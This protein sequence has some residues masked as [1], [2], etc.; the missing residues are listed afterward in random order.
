MPVLPFSDVLEQI[1]A[2]LPPAVEAYLVGGAVR[3]RLLNRHVYDLDF[4][5]SEEPLA[6]SRK[7]ADKSGGAYYPLDDKRE[8]GRVIIPR[9]DG[10]R[11]I[12]DFALIQGD[13]LYSDLQA[14]DFSINAMAL[15]LRNPYQLID[16][17]GGAA[18]LHAGVLRQCTTSS[19]ADDP[20]RSLRAV[21]LASTFRLQML[22]ETVQ[23][24][25]QVGHLLTRVSAERIRDELFR[26]LDSP[27]P[28]ANIRVLDMLD[29]LPLVLPELG[30]LKNVPQSSP[31]QDDVW[32]H[33]LDVLA[34]LDTIIHVLGG[35]HD[36]DLAANWTHG[37]LSV[38]LG[39]FRENIRDH[40][41]LS[42]S[43][44]RTNKQLLYLAALYHDIGKPQTLKED[45]DG[46][47]RFFNHDTE[48]A[49]IV[50]VRARRLRLSNEEIH[51]I[52]TIVRHH[53]RPLM[54]AHVGHIP[55]K[56]AIYRFYRAT[57][58]AGIDVCLHSLADT[59]ATFGTRLSEDIWQRDVNIVRTLLEAWWEQ[60]EV[61]VSPPALLGGRD[62][63]DNLGLVPGP[64]VGDLLEV[65]REAQAS[66]QVHDREEALAF[67]QNWLK[68]KKQVR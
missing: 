40:L 22:P 15:D 67:A 30:E 31:H 6:V 49:R 60:Q 34:K 27:N 45:D 50:S 14:R 25:R 37:Y 52:K 4:V 66:G 3:D 53:M 39:N 26:I 55:T 18:D 5:L 41:S 9:D 68:E 62:L 38:Q 32:H 28:A 42:I 20:I 63:I 13:D 23:A 17:L 58:A 35:D 29:L 64:L 36:P 21:R 11:L 8:T 48:G 12:L 1:C 54:L 44:G 61:S 16:P 47:I 2:E 43:P 57:Q 7:I 33:T 24:I 19:I 10:S 65:I 56:R 59:L 46:R 51:W